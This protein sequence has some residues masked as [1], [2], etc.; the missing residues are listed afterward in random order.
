MNSIKLES[1]VRWIISLKVHV[2]LPENQTQPYISRINFL[3]ISL[4]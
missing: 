3:Q 1:L 4:K 2:R